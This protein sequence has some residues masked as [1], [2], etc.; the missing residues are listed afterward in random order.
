MTE[1]KSALKQ[2]GDKVISEFSRCVVKGSALTEEQKQIFVKAVNLEEGEMVELLY[3]YDEFLK[4]EIEL[5]DRIW[6]GV[7]CNRIFRIEKDVVS[8]I[9]FKDVK[10]VEHV[11]NGWF[12]GDKLVFTTYADKRIEISVYRTSA[13]AAMKEFIEKRLKEIKQ[14]KDEMSVS[15]FIKSLFI[16][17]LPQNESVKNYYRVVSGQYR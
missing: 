5:K 8:E 7:T 9:M 14:K 17:H 15:E 4:P 3:D 2:L 16:T 6:V 13:C 12:K 11:N 1:I 10:S